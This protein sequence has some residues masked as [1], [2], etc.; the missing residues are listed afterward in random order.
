[1]QFLNSTYA[2]AFLFGLRISTLFSGLRI[3]MPFPIQARSVL[4]LQVYS[5]RLN[6]GQDRVKCYLNYIS[7]N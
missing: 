2:E 5:Y 6:I 1:M 3:S 7:I 4:D